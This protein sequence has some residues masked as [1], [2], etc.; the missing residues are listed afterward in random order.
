MFFRKNTPSKP[1]SE[2]ELLAAYKSTGNL[3]TL[4]ALYEQYMEMVFAVAYKYLRNQEESQDAV[5]LIFEHLIVKLR[6]H[7][8]ENFRT[9][10]HSVTRNHCLMT[11]RADKSKFLKNSEL[12]LMENEEAEH[13]FDSEPFEVEKQMG[14]L[15]DCMAKLTLEQ[16]KSITL[17]YMQEKCYQEVADITGYELNKVKSYIQNGKRNLKLC[18]E[19]TNG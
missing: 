11:L 16:N 9:W 2:A 13:P 15:D 5:M 7:E 12:F 1:L 4:G 3:E 6:T 14:N 18:L 10:L 19:K 8:V 17:F